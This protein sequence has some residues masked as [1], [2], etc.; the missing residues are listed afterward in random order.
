MKRLLLPLVALM[1]ASPAMAQTSVDAKEIKALADKSYAFYKARQKENG[2][3]EPARGG[4]GTTAL[5]A[6]AL[7][8]AGYPSDDPVVAKAI[9]YLEKNIQPDGGVYNKFLANYTTCIA[10]I[11]FK[12]AN[13]DGKYDKVIAN[14]AKFLKTL[15]TGGD[16]ENAAFGGVG[17]DGKGRGDV[18]NTHFYVEAL[19]ASGVSK[20]DP[21]IKNAIVFLSRC[22]NLPSEANKAAFAKKASEKD[23]GGF[24]YNPSDADNA[25]S[26]K[27]TPEGGLRSE[28][29][30]TY[31]GL[32]SFLY[33][34]VGKDDPRVKAALKW[35]AANYTLDENPGMKDSGLYY[36]YHTFAKA[37]AALGEETFTDAKGTKHAW[38]VELFTKLKSTQKAD[39]SWVNSNGAFLE[40]APELATSFALLSLSYTGK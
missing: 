36:Y 26:D 6:A 8:R 3:F 17:Y 22:Q 31:A 2:S 7:I 33:A 25:K 39:G 15:Q 10:L 16:Q 35:I 12:E 23:Q 9:G 5:I 14:A 28:G 11:T 18:S 40:N 19:I 1:I 4:P 30:M 38:K 37:M 13:K 32:K 24:V 34:G 27:K 20:D 29:G 21:A